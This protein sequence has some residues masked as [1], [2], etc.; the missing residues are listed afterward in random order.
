MEKKIF[1]QV[2][3]A[4]ETLEALANKNERENDEILTLRQTVER[5][6]HE[7]HAKNQ[8]RLKFEMVRTILL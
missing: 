6:E 7:K 1:L 8:D 5:L 3:S 2:I 4:L